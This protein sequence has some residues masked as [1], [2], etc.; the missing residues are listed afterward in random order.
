MAHFAKIESGLVTQVIVV[1]NSDI[2]DKD[3]N[4][5]EAV[6]AQY[7]A[8][9]LGGTWVQTSYNGNIR[10]NYAGIGFTYDTVRD[11]FIEP[12]PYPSWVLNETTCI[13]EAPVALPS[14]D[15]SYVWDESSQSWS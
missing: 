1:N 8:D 14:N 15:R 2:L 6:G 10:K 5:S 9:L 4:E 12:K 13:W 3:G 11:A 7:C